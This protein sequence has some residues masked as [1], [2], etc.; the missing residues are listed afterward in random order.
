MKTTNDCPVQ[1]LI[2]IET[3]TPFASED[4][5]G[6]KFARGNMLG[7]AHPLESATPAP[8]ENKNPAE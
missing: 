3:L 4:L 2:T 8:W 5:V 6:Q 7:G 1:D